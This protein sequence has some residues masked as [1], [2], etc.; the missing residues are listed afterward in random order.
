M[1]S[2]AGLAL[3]MAT[4]AVLAQGCARWT[5]FQRAEPPAVATPRIGQEVP[6]IDGETFEGSRLKLSEQRGKVVVLVFWA[7]WCKPCR[8][9]IPHERELAER[10][11]GKPV[12]I[13]GVNNDENLDAAQRVIDSQ[14]M[15][16]PIWKTGGTSHPIN[17]AWG[18]DRWP[19]VFVID[20][21]GILRYVRVRG[22]HLDN[23]IE[24]LLAEPPNTKLARK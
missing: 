16:W 8:D 3:W 5:L 12:A 11:R 9:M 7:S 15:T 1:R 20:R 18:V 2:M 23:A 10:Y 24:T 22:E 13:L 17:L 4:L 19:A 14:K 21:E 6:E